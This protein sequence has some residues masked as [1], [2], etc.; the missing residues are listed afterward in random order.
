[1]RIV[2]RRIALDDLEHVRT[3][4]GAD[5]PA[6]AAMV[7]DR[8]LDAIESLAEF[9]AR[10]RVGRVAGTRELVVAR[11]PFLVAYRLIGDT[12]EILRILHGA[13]RWPDR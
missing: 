12:V 8:I 5:A 11:T 6:V 4:I 2:W 9:P 1:M 13:Q 3:Y 7:A 10:G